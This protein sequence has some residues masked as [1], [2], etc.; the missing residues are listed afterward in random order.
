MCR[1]STASQQTQTFCMNSPD[2]L[3]AVI[4]QLNFRLPYAYHAL[5][6]L[7]APALLSPA[8]YTHHAPVT[9]PEA[10]C[11]KLSFT[12]ESHEPRLHSV[13]CYQLVGLKYLIRV[14]AHSAT[15]LT[16]PV[17]TICRPWLEAPRSSLSPA[18]GS[19]ST[20]HHIHLPHLFGQSQPKPLRVRAVTFNMAKKMPTDLP[21]ELLGRA[22]CPEGLDKYDIVVVG[23]QESGSSQVTQSHTL[24]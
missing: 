3:P 22:G 13:C 5:K 20:S 11:S 18:G 2:H 6:V 16:K 12:S 17:S 8:L 1:A 21:E 15:V 24:D 19:P 10:Q 7:C 4:G 23:T 9:Q 14:S